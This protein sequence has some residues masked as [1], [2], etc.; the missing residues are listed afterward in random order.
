MT[1]SNGKFSALLASWSRNSPVNSPHKGQWCGA[2][3]F[4]LICAWINAWVNSREAGDLRCHRAH[5][6]VIVMVYL[7][8]CLWEQYMEDMFGYIN[9]YLKFTKGLQSL[10]IPVFLPLNTFLAIPCLAWT[11]CWTTSR[12]ADVL[13]KFRENRFLVGYAPRFPWSNVST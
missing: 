9:V 3:M 2:L 5:Y 10:F 1:S 8:K 11:W 6:D 12:V 7:P 13:I 4:C